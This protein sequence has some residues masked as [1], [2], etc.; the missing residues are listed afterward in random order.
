MPFPRIL[1]MGLSASTNPALHRPRSCW[2]GSGLA[3]YR[4]GSDRTDY[5]KSSRRSFVAALLEI[6]ALRQQVGFRIVGG[7][8]AIQ[9]V[10]SAALSQAKNEGDRLVCANVFGLHWSTRLLAMMECAALSSYLVRQPG[11]TFPDYRFRERRVRPLC[12]LMVRQQIW[13]KSSTP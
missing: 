11:K 8:S 10:W 5:V 2:C 6:T 7:W 1:S 12:H 13:Q 3:Y 4:K 9:N